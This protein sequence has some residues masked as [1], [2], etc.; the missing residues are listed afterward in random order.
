[1][2]Y[3]LVW[4]SRIPNKASLEIFCDIRRPLV[5]FFIN[6]Q[7]RVPPAYLRNTY[8]HFLSLIFGGWK[9][10]TKS[11]QANKILLVLREICSRVGPIQKKMAIKYQR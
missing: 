6:Q 2:K 11:A 10:T 3:V 4:S 5:V 1:L 9:R 7:R 8:K